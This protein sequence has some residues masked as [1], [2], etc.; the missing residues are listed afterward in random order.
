MKKLILFLISTVLLLSACTDKPAILFNNA[1][2]TKDNV[3]NYT[4]EFETG[5]RVY[6]L[7]LIP[8]KIQSRFIFIQIVKKGSLNRLGYDLYW[9]KDIRLKDEEVFYY[10]DYVVPSEKGV[11]V[12]KVYSKDNPVKPFAM[13]QF[14]VF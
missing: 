5:Q 10:T 6:Y 11:Y 9:A 3:M 8:E 4:S 7:V 14:F 2:I 12:M 1:P 13:A